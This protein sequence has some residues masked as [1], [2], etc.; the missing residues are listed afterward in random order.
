MTEQ[1]KEIQ[2]P[3]AV[4]QSLDEIV[5]GLQ[6]F[7]IEENEE[8]LTV[9]A[10][11][12]IVKFRISNMCPE[13]ETKALVAAEELR[14]HA[15]MQR[16]K[17]EV[18]SRAITYLQVDNGKGINIRTLPQKDR[19]IKHPVS[20]N[21]EDIQVV[22][23]DSLLGWGQELV[24]VLWKVLMTHSQKIENQIFE[25]FPDSA[26]LTD[27]ER[28]FMQQAMA[29]IEEATRNVIAEEAQGVPE[30]IESEKK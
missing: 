12:R 23:R 19:F 7:G 24:G 17:C 10:S 11:K 22:L 2:T 14:G 13:E 25:Q 15:W 20:G 9:K 8:M 3:Q 5:A 16:I 6:G 30:L 27:V 1:L 28:R 4:P 29:E 18:L 26:V 21:M